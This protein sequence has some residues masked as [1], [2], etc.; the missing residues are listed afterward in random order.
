MYATLFFAVRRLLFLLNAYATGKGRLNHLHLPDLGASPFTS[1][2]RQ[3]NAAYAVV[4]LV[5]RKAVIRGRFFSLMHF[6]TLSISQSA[7]RAEF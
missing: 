1:G 6:H 2:V 7:S 5:E 3:I 4:A